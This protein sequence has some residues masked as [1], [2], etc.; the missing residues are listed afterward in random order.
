MGEHFFHSNLFTSL[1]VVIFLATSLNILVTSEVHL[2][3]SDIHR[4]GLVALSNHKHLFTN[5]S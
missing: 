5:D 2:A 1:F 4:F 3:S